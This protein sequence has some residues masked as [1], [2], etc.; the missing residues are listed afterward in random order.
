MKT[1]IELTPLSETLTRKVRHNPRD[2][3]LLRMLI[4]EA[5]KTGV[6]HLHFQSGTLCVIELEE[7]ES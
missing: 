7:K 3:E 4:K 1:E 2:L 6:L 5:K